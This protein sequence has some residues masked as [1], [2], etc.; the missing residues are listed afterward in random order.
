MSDEVKELEL[1]E[2]IERVKGSGSRFV[3][4]LGNSDKK[5]LA[6]TLKV[7]GEYIHMFHPEE[8][9]L[10]ENPES[11]LPSASP[12]FVCRHGRTSKIVADSL[13][14]RGINGY[15]LKGGVTR[16]NPDLEDKI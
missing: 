15:S 10:S 11:M 16:Y 8:L 1:E 4:V 3:W 13:K 7:D 14:K 12:I 5:L 9:L 6:E 2:A